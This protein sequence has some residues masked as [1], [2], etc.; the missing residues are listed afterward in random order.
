M[1]THDDERRGVSLR[2]V[3]GVLM[4][5]MFVCVKSVSDSV[6]VGQ[7]VFFRSIFAVP[8]LIG[9]LWVRDEFPSGMATT[10]PGAHLLRASLG[11]AA[12]FGSFASVARLSLGE[13]VLIAQLSPILMALAAVPLLGERL[14]RY[15]VGALIAGFAGVVVLV[16]PELA[17]GGDPGTSRLLGFGI[18]LV[19]AVLSALALIAVRHL[20]ETESPG[21]IALYFVVASAVG[22]AVTLPWGWSSPNGQALVLLVAAGLFGGFGHIASTLAFRYAEASRLAPFEYVALLWPILADLFI[23]RLPVSESFALAVPLIL[24]GAVV[25]AAE[26]RAPGSDQR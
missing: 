25:A 6:P 10:R 3:S 4:A 16:W 24:L 19:A 8:P 5:G 14:T 1:E 21:A 12:L 20:N 13:A 2:L 26:R 15:R 23:F 7:V 18:G 11:A 17:G 9:F 22:G